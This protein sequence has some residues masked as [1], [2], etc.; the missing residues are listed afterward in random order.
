MKA[1]GLIVVTGF[2]LFSCSVFKENKKTLRSTANVDQIDNK[3]KTTDSAAAKKP[4]PYPEIIT[5]KA[6]TDSGLFVVHKIDDKY[7]FEIPGSLLEHDILIVSRI[8]KSSSNFQKNWFG[9]AGDEINENVIEFTKGPSHKLFIRKISYD[10][11]SFDSSGNGMYRSVENS[12]MQPIITSFDIK[13]YGSDSAMV[14][15]VT[16]WLNIDN[17]LLFFNHN[18][19]SVFGIG[20]FQKDKSFPIG[21]QSFPLNVELQSVTSYLN[22]DEPLTFELNTSMVLLPESPMKPRYYDERVGYF[23]VSYKDFDD[24]GGVKTSIMINRWRLEPKP[25]DREKYLK[26]ELVEPLKPIVYYIDP[27]TPKKWIPYLMQGVIDWQKAFEKAGF[28]NAIYALEA[29]ENDPEWNLFDARHS[30]IIYKSS[31]FQNASGPHVH[32]PR[33]GE[34]LET[35]I[36]W[37]HNVIQL[38]HDWYMIQTGPND[39]R[40]RK[41]VFDDELMGRLIRFVICHEVGHTLGL[42]HNF[43]ASSTVPVD[44]LRSKKYLDSNGFCPSIM[45]YARFNYVAQPE[46]HFEANELLP[47]IG[48]YD[49]WA[50]NWGYRWLPQLK[51]REDEKV[52][53]DQWTSR[54]LDSDNRLFFGRQQDFGAVLDPRSQSE[55][56]GD[57]AMKSGNYGIENL[58]KVMANLIEWTREPNA[59]YSSLSRMYKEMINQYSRYIVHVVNNIARYTWTPKTQSQKENVLGFISREK[60]KE[61]VQFLQDQVFATPF[62]LINNDITLRV[63]GSSTNLPGDIQNATLKFLLSG[64]GIPFYTYNRMMLAYQIASPGNQ[65]SF[66]EL[67]TDVEDG[68]LKE[69]KSRSNIDYYRRRLQKIYIEKLIE[70]NDFS[71]SNHL[72]ET[73]AARSDFFTIVQSHMKNIIKNINKALPDLKDSDTKE[74]LLTLK[75]RLLNSLNPNTYIPKLGQSGSNTQSSKIM[76]DEPILFPQFNPNGCR[77]MLNASDIDCWQNVNPFL[78]QKTIRIDSF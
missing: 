40:A 17:N 31:Q 54:S 18:Y 64:Y 46:D 58:K 48:V 55:D 23:G 37:Y 47:G 13:C 6:I 21:V 5:K 28:K 70:M 78:Q 29:P 59:D 1:I 27:A 42:A 22:M 67:L 9:Y 32:D 56:L 72:F 2:F 49:E 65:Y 25:E 3:K 26:G 63:G 44:S 68:I 73:N 12:N 30:A 36:N 74:H 35:H 33:T 62:W 76:I 11:R 69:I 15:D 24:P 53:L 50:I 34:I 52:Y 38:L 57:N 14:I 71:I 10:E 39:P 75:T 77:K 51:T 16:D 7:F 19:K 45:D 66:D 20:G 61:A 60:Q 4:K 8:A 41:M 43:G